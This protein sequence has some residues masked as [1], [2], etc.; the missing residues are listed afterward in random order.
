MK[1]TYKGE[2]FDAYDLIMRKDN[3]KAILD[4]SKTIEIRSF[5]DKYCRMFVDQKLIDKN[6]ELRNAGKEDECIP[7]AEC[8]RGDIEVVHFRPYNNNWHLDAA[9]D[10]IGV[11]SMTKEDIEWLAQEFNYHEMDNEYQQYEHL[12]EDERPIFFYLHI[13]KVLNHQGLN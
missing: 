11:C 5:S 1:V 9:I 7:F 12:P 2:E 13:K 4:G 3:A 6:E 8:I 10:E